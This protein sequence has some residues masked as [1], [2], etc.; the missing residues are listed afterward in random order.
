MPVQEIVGSALAALISPVQTFFFPCST[1]SIPVSS[2][3]QQA[4]QAIV[5]GRLSLSM[6]LWSL[7]E[8]TSSKENYY[9]IQF[10][11]ALIEE[12]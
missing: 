11:V 4:W 7:H 3:A 9:C 6:C 12:E 8:W 10:I 5:L 1:I 2:I